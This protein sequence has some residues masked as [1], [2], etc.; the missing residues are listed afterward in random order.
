MF[1]ASPGP[2]GG[3]LFRGASKARP[4][5]AFQSHRYHI[6]LANHAVFYLSNTKVYTRFGGLVPFSP[7]AYG[8][9]GAYMVIFLVSERK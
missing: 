3:F 8:P 9:V 4:P 7:V 6:H 5:V 1:F 2:Y